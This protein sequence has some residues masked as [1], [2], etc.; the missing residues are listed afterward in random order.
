[1]SDNRKTMHPRLLLLGTA[2]AVQASVALAQL[3]RIVVQGAG[4]PEV[5]TDF[6]AAVAAAQA[7]DH[8]YLSGGTFSFDGGLVID[9]PLHL[10]GAGINPDSAQVTG[11]TTLASITNAEPLILT[12]AASGSSFTG[13]FFHTEMGSSHTLQIRFGTSNAD[14]QPTG[15]LFQR[16]RFTQHVQLA[17]DDDSEASSEV[18]VFDECIFHNALWGIARGATVTRCI[19]DAL[20]DGLYAIRYFQNGGLLVE[21]CTLLGSVMANVY[22][23]TIRNCISTSPS[24]F[25]YDMAGTTITN[26]VIAAPTLSGFGAVTASNNILN[27]DPATFF[28]S[29]TNDNYEF[30]DDLHLAPGCVGIG[31]GTDGT[32]LGIHGTA[33]PYKPG[34]VPLNPHYRSAV[35]DPSTTVAGDLPVNIR[36]A[37]QSH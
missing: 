21:N 29:E 12:S 16:C 35:I 18:T 20:S 17:Y 30:S 14:D 36:V 22:N 15:V 27:A 33:T 31:Y 23:G 6:S 34:A 3:P 13:I 32:D 1:M 10:I 7:N 26:C 8:I 11:V 24:Y 28:L 4:G 5:F 37:S 9:K 25:G 19:F 2:A